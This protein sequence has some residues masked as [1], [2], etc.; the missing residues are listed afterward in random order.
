M[1]RPLQPFGFAISRPREASKA[2]GR[3][4]AGRR[5][6]GRATR[7]DAM[8]TSSTYGMAGLRKSTSGSGASSTAGTFG[9]PPSSPTRA[10]SMRTTPTPNRARA[11]RSPYAGV[12]GAAPSQPRT[13]RARA[14]PARA[15]ATPPSPPRDASRSS[16]VRRRTR[17]APNPSGPRPPRR[18][19][20][21]ARARALAAG[22]SPPRA[23]PATPKSPRRAKTPRRRA[24]TH[25]RRPPRTASVARSDSYWAETPTPT[26][27]R[28]RSLVP[29]SPRRA[30]PGQ[31]RIPASFELPVP[32]PVPVPGRDPDPSS[33]NVPRRP[34]FARR[35][36]NRDARHPPALEKSAPPRGRPGFTTR[37]PFRSVCSR[38]RTRAASSRRKP[39]APPNARGSWRRFPPNR[40][41]SSRASPR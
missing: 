14:H 5:P 28:R 34:R 21:R 18:P 12:P 2:C 7:A 23:I 15:R 25:R 22:E 40:T 30:L 17:P 3:V 20:R 9:P 13:A 41:R 16:S 36:P 8:P 26:P 19:P 39:R 33:R 32:F 24:R 35:P 27:T 11:P 1:N 10:A 38:P 31:M 29:A 6:R 4:A 37:T